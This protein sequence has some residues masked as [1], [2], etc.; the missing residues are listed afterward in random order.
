MIEKAITSLLGNTKDHR[1]SCWRMRIVYIFIIFGK[2]SFHMFCIKPR[3][4]SACV[5][6]KIWH[7]LYICYAWWKRIKCITWCMEHLHCSL[8]MKLVIYLVNITGRDITENTCFWYHNKPVCTVPLTLT[9]N[10]LCPDN[11]VWISFNIEILFFLTKLENI[12]NTF[13]L[14]HFMSFYTTMKQSL[15]CTVTTERDSTSLKTDNH[16]RSSSSSSSSAAL[17]TDSFQ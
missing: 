9:E 6:F 2:C 3:L 7:F 5:I 10:R 1:T 12:S 16:L 11:I 14:Y 13:F 15:L 4:Q 17:L 8:N